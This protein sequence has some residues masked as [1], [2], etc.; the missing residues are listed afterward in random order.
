MAQERFIPSASLSFPPNRRNEYERLS[1]EKTSRQGIPYER[2]S[3]LLEATIVFNE[4]ESPEKG[5]YFDAQFELFDTIMSAK[6]GVIGTFGTGY[7]FYARKDDGG[8]HAIEEVSRFVESIRQDLNN[9]RA[10]QFGRWPCHLCDM[11][12]DLPDFKKFCK[13]CDD[14]DFKPRDLFKALPDLDYWIVVDDMD[15]ASID[16]LQQTSTDALREAGFYTSDSNIDK[17]VNKTMNAVQPDA[18]GRY[19][20]RFMLPVDTH[21]VTKSTLIDCLEATPDAITSSAFVPIAPFSLRKDWGGTDNGYDFIKDFL[22][23]FTENSFKDSELTNKLVEARQAAYAVVHSNPADYVAA[24]A[25]KEKRQL[26]TAGV[27]DCLE[28][29]I[30]SW[31]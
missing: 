31:G 8:V 19:N 21:M 17:A 22:F 4:D 5:A 23:S 2:L 30:S 11:A 29:R 9:D 13:P 28:K 18:A 3:R 15:E 1:V 25:S 20:P 7:P 26:E 14:V 27:R 12:N 10:R 16:A 6:D 24:R